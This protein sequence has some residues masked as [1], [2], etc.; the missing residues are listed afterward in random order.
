MVDLLYKR[1]PK[2]ISIFKVGFFF[3]KI[4][5]SFATGDWSSK[6]FSSIEYKL[7]PFLIIKLVFNFLD[8]YLRRLISDHH[9]A[10]F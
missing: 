8:K 4:K 3:K 7:D 9:Y 5:K 10:G 1:I 6:C 2:N